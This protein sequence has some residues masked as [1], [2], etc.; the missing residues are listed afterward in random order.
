MFRAECVWTFQKRIDIPDLMCSL[1]AAQSI[2]AFAWVVVVGFLH[3]PFYVV[4]L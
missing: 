3:K 1:P 4:T 2:K